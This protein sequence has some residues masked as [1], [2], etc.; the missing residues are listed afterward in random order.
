MTQKH[1]L[2]VLLLFALVFLAFGGF[3]LHCRIHPPVTVPW[4]TTEPK[5]WNIIPIISGL[6]SL[7][8]ITPLFCFRKTLP[9]GYVLNGMTVIIGTITMAQFSLSH[10]PPAWTLTAV[11]F[12]S[13]F[14]DIVLLWAK[15]A[16]GK[17]LFELEHFKNDET[18]ARG[19]RFFRYP[20][21]GWWWIHVVVLTVVFWLGTRFW[22]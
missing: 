18:A 2:R 6:I 16:V 21:M 7:L 15:F 17:A 4:S 22:F 1:H 9:F 8:V 12:Q 5:G 19:G 13:L 10:P 3:L 20:N 14:T 11:L